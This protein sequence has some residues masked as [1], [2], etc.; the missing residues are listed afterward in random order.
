MAEINVNLSALENK[1]GRLKV[2]RDSCECISDNAMSMEGSGESVIQLSNVD[3]EY[4]QIHSA[5]L[6]LIDNSIGFFE[7]IVSS[8][9]QADLKAAGNFK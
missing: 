2:L 1:I 9:A 6:T 5:M 7:N 8:V 4:E 3:A